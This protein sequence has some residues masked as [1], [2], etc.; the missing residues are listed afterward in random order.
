MTEQTTIDPA[1]VDAAL[2]QFREVL[3]SDGYLLRW[4]PAEAAQVVVHVEAGPDACADCLVPLPVMEAIMNDALEQTP[5]SVDH[6]VL[7]SS[8]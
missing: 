5:Y 2:Q 4:T 8:H 1:A 7:P 3:A 6:V